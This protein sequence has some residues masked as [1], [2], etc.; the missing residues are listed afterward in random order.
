MIKQVSRPL[1]AALAVA[2]FAA[3]LHAHAQ[4]WPTKPVQIVM[5]GNDD[6]EITLY[7]EKLAQTF[8][9]PFILDHRPGGTG[10]IAGNYVAKSAPDG[11]ALLFVSAS[12][13][14]APAFKDDLPY[15]ILKD[16]APVSL[17]SYVPVLLLAYSGFPANNM[18]EYIAYAKAHPNDILWGTSGSG[19]IQHLAGEW[20]HDLIGS[21]ATFVHYK[22][23]TAATNDL[24]TGRIHVQPRPV[25]GPMSFITTGKLK[26]L[27][28][29]GPKR[30]RFAPNLPTAQEAGLKGIDQPN[31]LGLSAPL[32]T[33][34]AIINKLSTE[35]H[36]IVMLPDIKAILEP[37][38][39]IQVGSTP[40]EFGKYLGDQVAALR[41]IV[42]EKGIKA[43][44]E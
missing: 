38:D 40:E 14:V 28:V 27:G 36:R 35:M 12:F 23:G 44:S 2:S 13:V 43:E 15:D 3:P 7:K 25:A 10:I 39:N 17:A 11:H 42:K 32:K 6:T 8:G 16:F 5:A 4:A 24:A 1:L 37:Q 20:M 30:D 22:N 29:I 18:K 26:P 19:G 41:R 9:K 34:R 31:F 33:D 21:P